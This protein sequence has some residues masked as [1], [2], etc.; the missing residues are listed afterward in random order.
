MKL[1]FVGPQGSGK[2]TQAKIISDKFRIPDISMGG[3]LRDAKGDLKK[4]I[5]FYINKGQ[6]APP[7]IVVEALK[8]RIEQ[9]DCKNGFVLDGFPRSE[10]QVRLSKGI[11]DFDRVILID[12][13]DEEA[14]RRLGS[15]LTCKKCGGVFN[16]IT[17]PPKEENKCDDCGGELFVRDDDKPEA[18]KKRLEIYHK[19]TKPVLE[20]YEFIRINGAQEI[21]KISKD[22]LKELEN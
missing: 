4:E 17:N 2:G 20:Y 3:L 7:E 21:N 9:E 13:S 16:K 22:I 6:L 5:D 18:I 11:I 10:E 19:E 12:I 1:L 15:R 8:Q 14:M